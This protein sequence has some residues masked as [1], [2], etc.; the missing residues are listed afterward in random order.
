MTK[1]TINTIF[2]NIGKN[3]IFKHQTKEDKEFLLSLYA[4]TREDELSITSMSLA[5]KKSLY[6]ATV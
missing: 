4:S 6:Q 1:A 5:E 2:E 3:L